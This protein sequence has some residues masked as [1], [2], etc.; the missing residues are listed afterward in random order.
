MWAFCRTVSVK[1]LKEPQNQ[2]YSFA[3]RAQFLNVVSLQYLFCL[4]IC[5]KASQFCILLSLVGTLVGIRKRLALQHGVMARGEW[6]SYFRSLSAHL[7]I[8]VQSL[9][10]A[11]GNKCGKGFTVLQVNCYLI[12][13]LNGALTHLALLMKARPVSS[14]MIVWL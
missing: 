9:L 12:S 5:L 1:H 6:R 14:L 10:K 4:G 11:W 13:F 8:F 7:I 3:R 2:R